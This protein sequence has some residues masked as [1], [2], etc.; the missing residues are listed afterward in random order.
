MDET[1]VPV[2]S[3][4]GFLLA[5]H[6]GLLDPNFNRSV[7]LLSA[8]T[9]DD[10]A[11]G[12]IINRPTG[13]SLG[14]LREDMKTPLLENLPVY[15]GGPVSPTEILLVAWKW[16]LA[17]Q[18]FRL[19]FGLEPAK[20]QELVD[21]DPTIEARAFLGYSGWSAGQLE[22]E[23]SRLDW[24]ISPFVHPFGKMP[25]QTLWRQFVERIRPEWGMLADFPDDPSMN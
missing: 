15:E 9:G 3:L 7:V 20:L 14:G 11:L 2:D 16:N 21:A 19:F 25:P 6:P 8:H 24:A 23:L 18:N 10:G 17:Q 4:A 22:V 13:K 1:P 12:I 5:A